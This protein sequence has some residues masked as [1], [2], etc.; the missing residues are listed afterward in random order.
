[1]API[2][3]MLEAFRDPAVPD[4]ADTMS[5]DW[6]GTAGGPAGGSFGAGGGDAGADAGAYCQAAC[7]ECGWKGTR[8]QS[9]KVASK[10]CHDHN[11]QYGDGHAAYIHSA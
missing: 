10:E 11:N 2:E 8:T 6:L 9:Y 5:D 1:M 3:K 4:G 7:D